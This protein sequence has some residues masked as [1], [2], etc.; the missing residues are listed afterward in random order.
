MARSFSHG[1]NTAQRASEDSSA[2]SSFFFGNGQDVPIPPPCSYSCLSHLHPARLV[3]FLSLPTAGDLLQG[4]GERATANGS[5]PR[6]NAARHPKRGG[7][8]LGIRFF[9]EFDTAVWLAGTLTRRLSCLSPKKKRE[10]EHAGSAIKAPPTPVHRFARWL[11]AGV[12]LL[13]PLGGLLLRCQSIRSPPTAL[14]CLLLPPPK[15][16]EG[17]RHATYRF[18]PDQDRRVGSDDEVHGRQGLCQELVY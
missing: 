12:S 13:C 17:F 2:A 14:C 18:D 7:S 10:A 15:G 16:A 9:E 8:L 6:Y 1:K 4:T 11:L 3:V 5:S